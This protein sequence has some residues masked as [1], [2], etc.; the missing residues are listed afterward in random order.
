MKIKN[1]ILN[2]TITFFQD[3]SRSE[4]ILQAILVGLIAGILVVLFKVGIVV[5]YDFIQNKLA[6]FH[7]WQKLIIFPIITTLG[8]LIS[9]ILVFKFA[10]ET[11]GSGI[12][13]VKMT[14][15]RIGK[16]TRL[17]SIIVK[18]FAGLAGIGTGLSLGREGPSV[19]LGAGAGA[20]VAKIFKK[21]GTNQHNLISAGAGAAIGATFNA[22][23]A[24]TLF[25]LEELSQNFSSSILFPVLIAT[26][27]ASE[28]TRYFLGQ[29]PSFKIPKIISPLT[30]QAFPAFVI[31]GILAG[32]LGVLF[33]K[34]IFFNNNLYEKIDLPN[35]TKPAIAGFAI[36][37]VGLFLPEILSS[38]NV[39]VDALLQSKFTLSMIFIIFVGKFIITPFC[40]GSGAA[41]GIFLPML[42]L[43][44]FLGNFIG[45]LSNHIGM[46]VDPIILSLVGMGAFLSATARTPITAVVMVFEMTGDY[47]HILPIMFSVA[48]ADLIAEKMNHAPIYESLILKQGKPTTET[49]LLSKTKVLTVMERDIQTINVNT[50]LVKALS[51]IQHSKY[52][53]IPVVNNKEKIVGTITKAEIEYSLLQGNQEYTMIEKIMNPEPL[54]I[55]EDDDLYKA[56]YILHLDE[57]EYLIAIDNAK[58][59]KGILTKE[60]FLDCQK[61]LHTGTPVFQ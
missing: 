60:P 2:K 30:F 13:Y 1:N 8:G 39:P 10:P 57:S 23:I 56:F 34:M 35:W 7:F 25:V 19:Q 14:L 31:L 33:A 58:K 20:L 32:V 24:G 38:G 12:P 21:R 52:D 48:I 45:I 9:G 55:K 17:R 51:A 5:I 40:F 43:G 28:I 36:G 54:V 61:L 26:V 29:N 27:S 3:I 6:G 50:P 37:I 4:I 11:K 53:I 49:K 18:F 15:A 59:V 41:G 42:M 16:G 47:T 44:A 46:H 22:P